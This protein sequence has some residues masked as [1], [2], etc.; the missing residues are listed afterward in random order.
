MTSM[1]VSTAISHPFIQT[2]FCTRLYINYPEKIPLVTTNASSRE[3]AIMVLL[4]LTVKI[5]CSTV[6]PAFPTAVPRLRDAR[7]HLFDSSNSGFSPNK[8]AARCGSPLSREK[9]QMAAL[10]VR[11]ASSPKAFS[12]CVANYLPAA[13]SSRNLQ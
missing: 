3:K 11:C 5:Y 2:I 7:N 12:G 6:P 13:M 10:C 4:S 1:K 8:N 9:P